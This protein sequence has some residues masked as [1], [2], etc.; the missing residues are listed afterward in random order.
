M[1]IGIPYLENRTTAKSMRKTILAFLLC[2]TSCLPFSAFAQCPSVT[3]SS[4]PPVILINVYGI[5]HAN[6]FAFEQPEVGLGLTGG[7][8]IGAIFSPSFHLVGGAELSNVYREIDRGAFGYYNYRSRFVEVPLDM[9]M[10]FYHSKTDG[11]YFILGLGAVFSQVLESN[12]PDITRNETFY[13]QM[14]LRFG[15]DHGISVQQKFNFFWGLLGKVDPMSVIGESFS[16]TNGS[17]YA[18][19]RL[20]LQF[21]L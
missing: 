9:R 15:F 10:R 7:F 12:D 5:P 14:F 3:G 6:I 8:Q 17:Y 13:H 4:D 20:G 11:A 1:G 21:G 19:I 16:Y 2:C 18:G